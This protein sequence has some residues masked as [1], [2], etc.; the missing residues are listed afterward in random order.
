MRKRFLQLVLLS[1]SFAGFGQVDQYL[2]G[3]A[4]MEGEFYD[5]ALFHL[6]KALQQNPG[7]SDIF[8]QLGISYFNLNQYPAARDAFYETEKRSKG[9]GSFYLAKSEIRLNHPQQALK[10]LRIHLS[11]RY[12]RSESEIL[13]DEDISTLEGSPGWQQLWNE[14]RWYS[15]RDMEFQNALFLK[16]QGDYLEAINVLNS[17]EKQ[18]YKK[19]LVQSEQA[20]IYQDL[21]NIKASRSALESAVKSDVRNLDAFQQLATMQVADGDVEEAVEA[22]DKVIRQ[23][24][25]HFEAYIQRAEARS[26]ADDLTGALSDMELYLTYFPKNDSALYRLGLIQFQHGKYLD[27][28]QSFNGSLELNRG[29]AAYYFA[30]GRTYAATGTTRY[31]EKDMSM[32]LDLDPLNGEIWYEKGILADHLGNR[33]TACHCYRKAYQYGVFEAG[34]LINNRCN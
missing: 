10:Y 18:G 21:G 12:K 33:D 30:R 28:I 32:A 19:S 34:E 17:L 11:S 8:Y 23:N 31:A 29:E 4:C 27:A 26:Q 1:M 22:L 13:L 24:P 7:N 5:S 15:T 25:A 2:A 3:R 16:S 20:S 6:E 14:K 9:M